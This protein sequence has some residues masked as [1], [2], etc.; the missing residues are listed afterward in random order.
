MMLNNAG[1]RSFVSFIFH[2]RRKIGA[3]NMDVFDW[4]I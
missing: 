3:E 4:T 2:I 1:G